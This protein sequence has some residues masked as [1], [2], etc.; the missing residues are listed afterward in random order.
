M[1]VFTDRAAQL[2]DDLIDAFGRDEDHE[3]WRP[4]R[5][6]TAIVV[7]METYQERHDRS[8]DL[9]NDQTWCELVPGALDFLDVAY[10]EVYTVT[11][12][13]SRFLAPTLKD[14]AA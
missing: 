13:P 12:E 9:T 1:T 5:I 2:H 10:D 8:P 7:S 6:E 3:A 14:S 11:T 4:G